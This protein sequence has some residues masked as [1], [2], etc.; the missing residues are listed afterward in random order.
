MTQAEREILG[1][2]NKLTAQ[3]TDMQMNMS[4]NTPT[5]AP[6]RSMMA[7]PEFS[8]HVGIAKT[9]LYDWINNDKSF[10]GKV[11]FK[12]G[13]HWYIDLKKWNKWREIKHAL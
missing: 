12:I 9:T 3:V 1:K 11:A 10:C 8:E 13:R 5:P 7:L 2:L 6:K 4:W